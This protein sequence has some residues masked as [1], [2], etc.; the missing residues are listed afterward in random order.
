MVVPHLDAC[1]CRFATAN[2]YLS[3]VDLARGIRTLSEFSPTVRVEGSTPIY[4][5]ET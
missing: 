1:V 4:A 2:N 5:N 3:I